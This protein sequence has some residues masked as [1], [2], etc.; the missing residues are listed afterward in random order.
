MKINQLVEAPIEMDPSEPNNPTIYGH[1]KANPMTLKGR[2]MQARG[3]LKELARMADSDE[4]VV[5][6]QIVKLSKGGIFMGLEQNFEQIRHGIEELAKKRKKGGINSRGIN[7][8]IGETTTAGS[9]TAVVNP[10]AVRTKKIKRVAQNA[11]DS[12]DNLFGG[13]TVKR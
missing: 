8:D 6:Q 3:Q 5:W 9:V 2:I 13:K 1:D 12:N 4:L 10:G 11:L 7:K